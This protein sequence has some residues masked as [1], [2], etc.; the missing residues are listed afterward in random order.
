MSSSTTGGFS[1]GA[2][3][4]S[5]KR[6]PRADT[7]AKKPMRYCLCSSVSGLPFTC[8]IGRTEELISVNVPLVAFLGFQ[9]LDIF[10][11]GLRFEAARMLGDGMECSLDV[12]SHA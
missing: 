12:F 9:L 6:R 2:G 8:W 7:P 10:G 4:T 5:E 11:S 1:T 3:S